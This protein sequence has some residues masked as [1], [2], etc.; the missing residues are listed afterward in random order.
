LVKVQVSA[1]KRILSDVLRLR[2]VVYQAI[3]KP[4]DMALI[5]GDE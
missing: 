3:G 5:T 4:V 2:P 1:D